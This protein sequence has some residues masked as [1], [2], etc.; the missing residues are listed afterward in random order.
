MF[1]VGSKQKTIIKSISISGV[2][3]HTN[4]NI[5]L[6]LRPAAINS[7]I[8][9]RRIDLPKNESLIY[10][11]FDTVIETQLGTVIS[12]DYG[13]KIS[14]IEHLMA[15][16]SANG[17]D[18]LIIECNGNEVPVM[19][20]SS[21]PFM[22]L[23][24]KAGIKLLDA[25]KKYVRL[26]KDVV[27]TEGDKF[28]KL[29]PFD[30]FKMKF[31]IEFSSSVIGYQSFESD[32]SKELFESELS[33]ART[34]GFAHEVETL[35]KMG[36]ARGGSFDNAIVIDNDTVLNESGLRFSD[37]FV[38]HKML[39]AV[40]DL[41]LAQ[42]S[43]LGYYHGYKSGHGLN[44][45]LLHVLLNDPTAYSLVTAPINQW[46]DIVPQHLYVASQKAF[47]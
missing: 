1:Y 22:I 5:T 7:G 36:L 27:V 14:T 15:A 46:A 20:G 6:T 34:F 43:I 19:D 32:F 45:K 28:A 23:F 4:E 42:Y 41:A 2:G 10:A 3:L 9:F 21:H 29:S 25:P 8:I 24:D 37:E 39:D 11:R 30:G 17:I 26:L 47:G 44:N 40:G 13:H 12:N 16:I 33:S 35:K 38:R 18:N 31:E